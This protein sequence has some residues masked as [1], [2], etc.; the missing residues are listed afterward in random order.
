MISYVLSVFFL[1]VLILY[2]LGYSMINRPLYSSA[3]AFSVFD[4][5]Y[6][7]VLFLQVFES[8]DQDLSVSAEK[9]DSEQLAI[10]TADKLLRVSSSL[11]LT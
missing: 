10:K 6:N 7:M 9:A 3:Y 4:I 11:I 1:R 2:A 5:F 8:V